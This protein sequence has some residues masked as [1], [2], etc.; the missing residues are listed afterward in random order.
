[1]SCSQGLLLY[2]MCLEVVINN[3]YMCVVLAFLKASNDDVAMF[4][5]AILVRSIH[6]QRIL[7]S[8]EGLLSEKNVLHSLIL[9]IW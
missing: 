2:L 5:A 9:L 7:N 3:A 8:F 4:N 1:M 6:C